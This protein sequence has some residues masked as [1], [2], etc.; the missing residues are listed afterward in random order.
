MD[1]LE[2]LPADIPVTRACAA[3]GASRA[4]LYRHTSAPVPPRPRT[5]VPPRALSSEDRAEIVNALHSSEFTDQ[6]PREVYAALLSMGIYLASVRTMY[7]ILEQLGENS[8]RRRGHN[9]TTIVMPQLEATRPHQVWTWDITKVHGVQRGA[10]YFVFVILDLFSRYVVG[11][12]VA[13]TENAKL[14]MHLITETV[15]AHDIK[16]G[17]LTIHSDRGSPMKAGSMT[18]LLASLAIEQSFSRPRVSNDNPFVESHFK[19]AKYQPDFP[20]CFSSLTHARGW[21]DELFAWYN[22]E[23]HHQG[24]ALFTP[25]DVFHERVPEVAARRQ[26]ALDAAFAA[27]PERFVHGQP[28]V[29]LPPDRVHINLP[30]PSEPDLART[31]TDTSTTEASAKVAAE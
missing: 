7:R 10:F 23:H 31:P 15:R 26:Q 30:L 16:P 21:F 12:L 18:Q 9:R 24:L 25:A 20:E 27:H 19:T 29:T 8:E 17:T 3:L 6:P 14:A 5:K 2:Q 4:T 11:W 22:N 1:S 13:E 28:I